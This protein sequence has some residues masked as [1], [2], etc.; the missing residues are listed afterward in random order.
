MRIAGL[1]QRL[2][3]P[4]LAW[5]IEKAKNAHRK[6]HPECECCGIQPSFW[7]LWRK[8]N[9][10]HHETPVHVDPK[11]ACDPG[12]LIT[13]CRPCHWF[14]GHLRDWSDWNLCVRWTISAIRA[15]YKEYTRSG[16]RY[17]A[18]EMT[19]VL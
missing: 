15:A 10:V 19:R 8:N 13:L 6:E 12:N 16:K 3:H 9:D 5:Q 7:G 18:E 17:V 2:Q 4:V 14:V 11:K 1:I